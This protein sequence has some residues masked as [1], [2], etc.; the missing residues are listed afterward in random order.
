MGESSFLICLF[1]DK[2]ALS[3]HMG[4][5]NLTINYINGCQKVPAPL[6]LGGGT[7]PGFSSLRAKLSQTPDCES[8]LLSAYSTVSYSMVLN[9]KKSLFKRFVFLIQRD[10][11]IAD[12]LITLPIPKGGK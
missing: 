10:P 8:S 12:Q 2:E 9:L 1:K 5:S 11:G 6:E 7:D 4:S 3:V